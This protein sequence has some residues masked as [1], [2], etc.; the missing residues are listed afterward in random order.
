MPVPIN[1]PPAGGASGDG[2]KMT[3]QSESY[4]RVLVAVFAGE[5]RLR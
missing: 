5:A 1:A 2:V 3:K 4:I